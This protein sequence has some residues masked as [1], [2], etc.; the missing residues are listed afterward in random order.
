MRIILLVCAVVAISCNAQNGHQKKVVLDS[1]VN[2]E[3]PWLE[4]FALPYDWDLKTDNNSLL[5][6]Y[7]KSFDST[8]VIHLKSDTQY[9]NCIFYWITPQSK[10]ALQ[11]VRTHENALTRF[12]GISLK[13]DTTLWHSIV[14]EIAGEHFTS[15]EEKGYLSC[16]DA[17]Y[18]FLSYNGQIYINNNGTNGE[19]LK[20]L[21]NFLNIH[22][23]SKLRAMTEKR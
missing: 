15:K 2:K 17:P 20:I 6:Y 18:Y 3:R 21:S 5:F 19:S 1:T 14:N 22:L 7:T 9:L 16:C 23:I 12:E 11:N 4:E 10:I 8:I 13:L